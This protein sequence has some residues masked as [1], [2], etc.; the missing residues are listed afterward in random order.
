MTPGLAGPACRFR[1]ARSSV[2]QISSSAPWTPRLRRELGA[3]SVVMLGVGAIVGTGVF[4]GLGL[5]AGVAGPAMLAATLL[6]GGLALCN[7]LAGA[8]LA[9]ELPGAAGAYDQANKS[10]HPL[11]GFS[12]GWLY[13]CAKSASAA[14][15]ALALAGYLLAALDLNDPLWRIGVGL[16]VVVVLT[17]GVLSG[18]RHTPLTNTAA[19]CLAAV[20]LLFFVWAGLK[21]VTLHGRTWFTPF[22]PP[23]SAGTSPL[24]ALL[25]ATA[26]M[27]VAYCGFGRIAS[28]G[29][30]TRTP[31]RTIPT[32]TVIAIGAAAVLYLLVGVTALGSVGAEAFAQMT[33]DTAA[34]L[35]LIAAGLGVPGA[36]E[37]LLAAALVALCSVLLHLILGLSR[38]LMAMSRRRDMPPR[39][40]RVN[41]AGRTPE[42]AVAATGVLIAALVLIGDIRT[43]WEFSAFTALLYYALANLAAYALPADK[44]RAPRVVAGAG[45]LACLFLAFW[46]DP[47]VWV[48]G[49]AMVAVGV[50][51]RWAMHAL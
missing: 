48:A 24:R 42:A 18:V 10:L 35:E 13:L 39:L 28:L 21:G 44:R 15:A 6:A 12:A 47:A 16:A 30:E 4:V 19:V 45:L 38:M 34:P 33:V 11:L 1:E 36:R 26:L 37:L 31:E 43:T 23:P 8:Q 25:H 50:G 41:Q 40:A 14:T 7:G 9:G 17:V 3:L 32:A 27:A 51:W 49:L 5:A 20:G 29:E 22:F 2:A 46:V